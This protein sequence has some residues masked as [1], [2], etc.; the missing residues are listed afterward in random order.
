MLIRERLWIEEYNY[1]FAEQVNPVLLSYILK[2]DANSGKPYHIH[3]KQTHWHLDSKE[4]KNLIEWI[5]NLLHRDY[6][7]RIR[8]KCPEVWGVVCNEGD[9]VESHCHSPSQYSFVYYVNVPKGSS[10]LVFPTSGHRVKPVAGKMVL[11]D[12]KLNHEV[13]YN[14]CT[15]RCVI[16]GNFINHL[17][18]GTYGVY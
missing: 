7:F 14:K 13:K 8:L 17:E 9:F 12:S 10:S 2:L 6:E 4:V 11:F 18:R 5:T 3:A 16:S 1:P 15:N